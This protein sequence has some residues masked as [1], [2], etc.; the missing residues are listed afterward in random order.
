MSSTQRIFRSLLTLPLWMS[1]A[2]ESA[3]PPAASTWAARVPD[4]GG[5]APP[6]PPSVSP[7]RLHAGCQAFLNDTHA[8]QPKLVGRRYAAEQHGPSS[9][10]PARERGRTSAACTDGMAAGYPCRGIGLYS[11]LDLTELSGS[12]GTPWRDNSANDIWGWADPASGREFALIGVQRGTAFVE[13]TDPYNP[14][15]KGALKTRGNEQDSGNF[16][17]DVKTYGHFAL[18]VSEIE[19]HGMQVFDLEGL[20]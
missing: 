16:W 14:V 6:F 20:P 12:L 15:Y 9:Y 11:M 10:A 3:E 5:S 4:D 17:R 18:I 19:G 13:I 2:T 1:G 8:A 7:P